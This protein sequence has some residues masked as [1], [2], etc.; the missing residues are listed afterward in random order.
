MVPDEYQIDPFTARRLEREVGA[1]L[2]KGAVESLYAFEQQNP[3]LTEAVMRYTP[4]SPEFT[5]LRALLLAKLGRRA[6][7]REWKEVFAKEAQEAAE[8]AARAPVQ[9]LRLEPPPSEEGEG[10]DSRSWTRW[11]RRW[12]LG[13]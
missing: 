10:A 1:P 13:Q 6:Y 5:W 8:A 2:P 3:E 4:P 11:L 12:L 7:A 9:P